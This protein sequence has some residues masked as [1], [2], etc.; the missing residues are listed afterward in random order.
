[1]RQLA[2]DLAAAPEPT[3]D[4]FVPGRNLEALTHL[5]TAV[6]ARGERFI[7]LWGEPGCGRTHLL[8]AAA[9]AAAPHATY[10]ACKADS[11][12]V[13]AAPLLAA[14]DVA[15]LGIEAQVA[16]FNRYNA[17]REQRGALITSGPMPPA[18]L[19]LRAD[20]QSRLSWGLVLQLHALNDDE[21]MLALTQHASARGFSLTQDVL[22]YLLTHTPRNMGDLFATLDALDRHSLETKRAV[23]VPLLRDF[24]RNDKDQ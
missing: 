2:L 13:D 5:Q 24:L 17:L 6:A 19:A 18:Q 8:R 21:K 3:F 23:T 20:L 9:A 16:L 10:V 22:A 12:F 4:T 15:F 7:Y 11:A 14:D 1:M